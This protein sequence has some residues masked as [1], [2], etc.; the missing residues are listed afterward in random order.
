[1]EAHSRLGSRLVGVPLLWEIPP[2]MLG[3]GL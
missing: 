2:K 1:M 3:K